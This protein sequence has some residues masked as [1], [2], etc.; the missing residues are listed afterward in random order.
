VL[1]GCLAGVVVALL[2]NASGQ[3]PQT[4]TGTDPTEPAIPGRIAVLSGGD[5]VLARV[6]GGFSGAGFVMG[7]FL[8][9]LLFRIIFKRDW[10]A[11]TVF[12]VLWGVGIVNTP[13]APLGVWIWSF[14]WASLI[15][16]VTM[17][18][19]LLALF[20]MFVC[21]GFIQ[22]FPATLNFSVWWAGIGAIGP[23]VVLILAAYGCWVS[24]AGKP[25]F[26]DEVLAARS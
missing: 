2:E 18:F 10:L 24:I 22:S 23:L 21:G 4:W 3:L 26:R 16:I 8:L 13:S 9:L 5:Q 11:T 15:F 12:V 7:I 20:V 6:L 1:A 17:R 14:S 19:G 25:L